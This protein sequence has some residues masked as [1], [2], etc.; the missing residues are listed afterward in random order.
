MWLNLRTLDLGFL[1]YPD[2]EIQFQNP[3]KIQLSTDISDYLN[4]FFHFYIHLCKIQTR[5]Q[6]CS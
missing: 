3:D 4:I 6:N 5:Y 1:F 2:S